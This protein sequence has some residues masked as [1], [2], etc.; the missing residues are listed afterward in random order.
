MN[1]N[2]FYNV[3]VHKIGEQFIVSARRVFLNAKHT[4]TIYKAETFLITRDEERAWNKHNL[5]VNC[6]CKL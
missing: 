2:M 1:F 6:T 3:S 5:L 4:P